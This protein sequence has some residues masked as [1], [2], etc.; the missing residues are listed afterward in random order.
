LA[1]A[2]EALSPSA[3]VYAAERLIGLGSGL[4]P[5]GDDFLCGF[6]AARRSLAARHGTGRHFLDEFGRLLGD[7]LRRTND[8]SGA[9]LSSAASGR[10]SCA[11]LAFADAIRAE[12]SAFAASGGLAAQIDEGEGALAEA[13]A[14]LCTIGH[15][16][17]LDAAEGFL[18]GLGTGGANRYGDQN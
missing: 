18:Y 9:F 8:I 4:T 14:T 13:V 5:A 17:G 2:F 6:L 16:S 3:A 1:F 15:S 7:V 10:F 11:L 12:V